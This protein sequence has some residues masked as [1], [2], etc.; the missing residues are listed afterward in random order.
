MRSL[1]NALRDSKSN[2]MLT[3]SIIIVCSIPTICVGIIAQLLTIHR[4]G[5]ASLVVNSLFYTTQIIMTIIIIA[6]ALSMILVRYANNLQLPLDIYTPSSPF[7]NRT[8][9]LIGWT[10]S[11]L[12]IV[13]VFIF[14]GLN[15]KHLWI[16]LLTR[17][18]ALNP[19][20]TELLLAR[21]TAYEDEGQYGLAIG[22]LA[23][24]VKLKPESADA[25]N[26]LCWIR[27]IVVQ[28]DLA[29]ANCNESLRIRPNDSH[30]LDSRA[31]VYLKM[32]NLDQAIANY[33]AALQIEPK[34]ATSLY[35]RGI[36]RLRAGDPGA[37]QTDIAAAKA[38]MPTVAEKF[39]RF[40]VPP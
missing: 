34:Q 13:A 15:L 14:F 39:A 29:L 10:G 26:S 35:G 9:T 20:N 22:D 28:L 11:L 32:G 8:N 19:N 16:P 2:S 38:L 18:L 36:A 31:F 23:Q 7:I 27:A 12:S 24:I 1:E 17:D 5:F 30:T 33:D 4:D 40:G 21:A 3:L 25:L 37:A 6:A